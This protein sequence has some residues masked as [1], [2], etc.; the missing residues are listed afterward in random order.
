M[1]LNHRK[2][3]GV[4]RDSRMTVSKISEQA[5]DFAVFVAYLM[6]FQIKNMLHG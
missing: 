5:Y 1:K 2:I 3:H 6:L 4:N